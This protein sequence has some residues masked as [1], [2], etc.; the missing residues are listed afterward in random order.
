MLLSCFVKKVTKEDDKGEEDSDFLLPLPPPLKTA[1]HTPQAT[2]FGA[3]FRNFVL[4]YHLNYY[5]SGIKTGEHSSPL[6]I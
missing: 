5:L 4:L 3:L 1:K 2:W 6:R